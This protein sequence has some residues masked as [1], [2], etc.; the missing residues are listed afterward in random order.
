MKVLNAAELS[1][2]TLLIV[3]KM[4]KMV[5]F[6]VVYFSPQICTKTQVSDPQETNKSV[7]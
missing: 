5:K 1:I 2:L 3:F 7:S 4:S 6:Y